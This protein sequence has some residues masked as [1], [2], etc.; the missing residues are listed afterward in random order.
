M[1]IGR[2]E[3]CTRILGI[4]QGYEGLPVRDELM[5]AGTD[6]AYPVMT[7]AWQPTPDEI[8]AIVAGASIHVR[9]LGTEHPP[10]KVEVGDRPD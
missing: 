6:D 7:T 1:L 8:A 9:I 10:I 3:G 5:N 4:Q 2:I